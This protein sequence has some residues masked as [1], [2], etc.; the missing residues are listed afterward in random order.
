MTTWGSRFCVAQGAA[1][2]AA[3]ARLEKHSLEVHGED[4]HGRA[5][6]PDRAAGVPR[7]HTRGEAGLPFPLFLATLIPSS[8]LNPSARVDAAFLL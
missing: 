2:L 5:A 6:E 7:G 4:A 3:L 1:T 8:L